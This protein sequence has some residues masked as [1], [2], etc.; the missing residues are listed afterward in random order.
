[1]AEEG[2][3]PITTRSQIVLEIASA[4]VAGPDRSV[5]Q[6][7]VRLRAQGEQDWALS[8]LGSSSS[9]GIRAVAAQGVDLAIVNPAATLAAAC[10][11]AG[12]WGAPQPVRAIAVIPSADEYVFAV[13][14]DLGLATIEDIAR[15]RPRLRVLMRRQPDHCLHEMFDDIAAAA[16]FSRADIAAWGGTIAKQALRPLQPGMPEFS[17]LV[18]GGFD[19]LFDEGSDRW[20]DAILGA[21][22]RVLAF[23]EATLARLEAL[24]YR[25]ARL[26]RAR[27]P[28][29]GADIHTIDF[30]GWPIFVHADLAD[31]R[32]EQ[33]CAALE[34]RAAM[35]GWQ[36]E[37]PLP[38]PRMAR[39]APDTPQSTPLHPAAERFW[40][41]RGYLD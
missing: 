18:G 14:G 20:V 27:F 33:I 15:L 10:R 26:T 39:E 4:L 36:G 31:G 17:E 6:A 9:D 28:H 2:T 5:R 41:K 8:L 22:W 25:R 1:M 13:R 32:V 12:S 11:G 30:S 34:E 19:A 7:E 35:I 24:G 38:V 3:N 40:R 21:G 16:G 37:G 23:S 29:L